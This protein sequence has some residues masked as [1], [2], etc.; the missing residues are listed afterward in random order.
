MLLELLISQKDHVLKLPTSI[1]TAECT[2]QRFFLLLWPLI[3]LAE[4]GNYEK[5]KSLSIKFIELLVEQSEYAL[6]IKVDSLVQMYN[7]VHTN[8]GI[9]S[10]AFEKLIELCQRESCC[11][12]VVDRARKI[13]QDSANWNLST[14]ERRQLYKIVGRALDSLGEN[15]CAYAVISAYLRLYEADDSELASASDDARRCVIM[16]IKAVDVINFAELVE[17]PAIKQ[18]MEK[19]AKVFALLNL[20]TQAS[21]QDFQ[22]KL[23]EYRDLMTNE[24]LTEHELVIKKSYV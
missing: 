23:S 7:S 11:D 1:R 15:G 6:K 12:I 14:G 10:Y 4:S 20:F 18:L 9:K 21:A 24:G 2:I 22:A 17:L 16:A 3:S 13:V 5:A 8:S 19:H